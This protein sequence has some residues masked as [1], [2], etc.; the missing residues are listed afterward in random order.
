MSGGGQQT[1]TTTQQSTNEP[2]S[3]AQPALKTGIS[4]ALGLYSSGIGGQPYTG[5]MVV[6]YANQSMDA[7]SNIESTAK[8]AMGANNP[9]TSAYNATS[10]IANKGFNQYQKQGLDNLSNYVGSTYNSSPGF[11]QIL[12][13][14]QDDTAKYVNMGASAAGRTGSG[15]HQ[16]TLGREIGNLTAN[17]RYND[18][19]NWLN[20]NSN[21]ANMGQMGVQNQLQASSQLPNAFQ[22]QF[23]PANALLGVGGAYEDL[24]RRTMDDQARIFNDTQ[25]APWEQIARLNAVASGLGQYGTQTTVAQQ[26]NQNSGGGLGDIAGLGLTL[27]SLL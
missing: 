25:M 7:F 11:E 24:A 22:N 19:N 23:A 1:Q 6:P 21:L 27:L 10:N 17:M 9:F 15:V 16:G 26:P 20:Q 4:D 2:W 5:S 12:R 3:Y 14:A 8:N 13:Q 18:Y